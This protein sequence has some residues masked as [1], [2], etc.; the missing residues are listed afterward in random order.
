MDISV[1]GDLRLAD[2]HEFL[3]ALR[4]DETEREIQLGLWYW[5]NTIFDI[6]IDVDGVD[7]E[8][9]YHD[10]INTEGQFM[11]IPLGDGT[12]TVGLTITGENLDVI[13]DFGFN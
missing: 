7:E 10:Q 12:R 6:E 1:S 5:I 11:N 2:L 8:G 13:H 9:P 4:G 3:D